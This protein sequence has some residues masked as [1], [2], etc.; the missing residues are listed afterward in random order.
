[1][2][3]EQLSEIIFSEL[4]SKLKSNDGLSIMARERA[5]FEG[6]LKVELCEILSHH[7]YYNEIIPE[8][9]WIDISIKDWLIELKTVNTN[10]RFDGVVLKHRPITKNIKEVI[11]DIEN[12]RKLEYPN[13]MVIFISFPCEHSNY[14]WQIL[15]KRISNDIT[16]LNH[17]EFK[18]KNGLNGIV[19]I[20]LV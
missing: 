12:L 18:F 1:M 7:F 10:Y 16:K 13:K 8:K 17:R 14:K 6:W 4:I 2:D 5:K 15:L 19:Y 9:G 3:F 11:S 20:G